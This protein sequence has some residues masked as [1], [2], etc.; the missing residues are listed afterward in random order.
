MTK[1]G[2]HFLKSEK[3]VDKIIEAAE[4][5]KSD[6][7]LEIGPGRGVLTEALLKK[8][9]K[10]ISIEKDEQLVEY[11]K[12]KFKD[13][14]NLELIHDDILK[15]NPFDKL[16]VKNYKVVAN[17][18][19][20]ITGAI[21]KKFL[22]NEYQPSLMVLMVQKEVAKRIVAKP[23]QMSVL[24]VSVQAYGQPKIISYVPKGHF[25]PPPKVDSAIIKI[26]NISK[27]FFNQLS[28]L[29][30]DSSIEKAFFGMAKKGF[31]HK[32]KMLKNNLNISEETLKKC[33]ISTKCR[34]Q[35]LGL[36]DW[37]KLY[38]QLTVT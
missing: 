15:I 29:N 16:R 34:A 20:Y 24:S 21:L 8:S 12:E 35:E 13:C 5:K 10:V 30:L 17:I 7:I 32:R 28:R 25:S 19:Y 3:I 4:I 23:P 18:P 36:E 14:K 31:S 9:K 37:G 38:K 6:V 33:G 27:D 2:Q 1:L 26:E 11:L 22:S